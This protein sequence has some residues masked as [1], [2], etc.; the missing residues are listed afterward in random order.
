MNITTTTTTFSQHWDTHISYLLDWAIV[1]AVQK[2][3]PRA[4]VKRIVKAH[5]NRNVSKNADILVSHKP[6]LCITRVLYQVTDYVLPLA[7]FFLITCFLC[8]SKSYT[9]L[10]HTTT[11]NERSI[12]PPNL[13]PNPAGMWGRKMGRKNI[14]LKKCAGLQIDARIVDPLAKGW[15]EANVCEQCSESHRGK[16][17]FL[18]NVLASKVTGHY[19]DLCL[20]CFRKRCGNS[21]V[22]QE[23]YSSLYRS[24][25]LSL[26]SDRVSP[27]FI[28]CKTYER[29]I[30]RWA[31]RNYGITY[32][33]F[34]W[35]GIWVG[36]IQG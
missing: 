35:F 29:V 11:P 31:W 34:S 17:L 16:M 19:S 23:L 7:R 9:R 28:S 12:A 33:I 10:L 32:M 22:D 30:W 6:S 2:L 25:S 15:W 5:A 18:H 4:T 36:S 3:Y 8:K 27:L 24:R 26:V 1:M 21:R 14:V 20:V 13:E